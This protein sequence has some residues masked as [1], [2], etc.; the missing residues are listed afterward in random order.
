MPNHGIQ[1][2][3]AERLLSIT[4]SVVVAS[5]IAH[6]GFSHAAYETLARKT[7]KKRNSVLVGTTRVRN[8]AYFKVGFWLFKTDINVRAD[9]TYNLEGGALTIPGVHPR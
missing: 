3:L 8:R 4:L 1:P 9:G 7:I 2:V 6:G 5:N